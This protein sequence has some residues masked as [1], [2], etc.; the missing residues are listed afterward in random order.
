MNQLTKVFEIRAVW[1]PQT[2]EDP[3]GFVATNEELGLVVEAESLDQ[4]ARKIREVAFDL[5]ELN[6]L[7]GLKGDSQREIRPAFDIRHLLGGDSSGD[8]LPGTDR[9]APA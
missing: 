9:F 2:G 3:A 5:F 7:P 1:V 8:L 4:L 6:V